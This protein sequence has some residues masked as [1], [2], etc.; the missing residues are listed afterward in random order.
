[1]V[2]IETYQYLNR[3]ASLPVMVLQ[4]TNDGYLPADAARKL[5]GPDT[6]F[7]RLI[8]IEAGNHSFRNACP[9]LYSN[10]ED[11]LKWITA[12]R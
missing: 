7:R 11:A 3:I 1:M 5:F 9:A 8:P 2:E 4:S 12:F 10:V 6:E